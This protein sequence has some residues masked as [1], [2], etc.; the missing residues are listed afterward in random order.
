MPGLLFAAQVGTPGADA[1]GAKSRRRRRPQAGAGGHLPQGHPHPAPKHFRTLAVLALGE[2]PK[3]PRRARA[4]MGLPDRSL[5]P[6]CIGQGVRAA[7][8][9]APVRHWTVKSLLCTTLPSSEI[10]TL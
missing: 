5:L 10:S 4:W 9:D 7:C 6:G 3:R 2:E 1:L 8:A